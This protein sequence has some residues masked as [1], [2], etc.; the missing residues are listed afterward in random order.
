MSDMVVICECWWGKKDD[1]RAVYIENGESCMTSSD[2]R[3]DV[4]GAIKCRCDITPSN[5]TR[6]RPAC[7]G[8]RDD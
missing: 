4:M 8:R 3:N 5:G 2:E 6:A 7:Q 1:R